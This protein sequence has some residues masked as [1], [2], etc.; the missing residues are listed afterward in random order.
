MVLTLDGEEHALSR[1][2]ARALRDRL[3]AAV[4]GRREFLYT[5]GEHRADGSYAV[6]RRAAES[7]GHTKVFERF[8]ALERLYDRLPRTFT[9][10]D[11]GAPGLT[12]GRRHVVL[13][14]LA[15]HPG[16]DCELV[17]RQPLTVRKR[18]A[19]VDTDDGA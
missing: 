1:A 10:E 16:F 11:V 17:A 12:G 8:G 18:A 14:H 3:S 5:A 9:A 2:A 13:R 6:E 4:A 19:A 15:E 7:A